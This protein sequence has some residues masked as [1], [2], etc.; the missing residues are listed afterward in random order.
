MTAVA[1]ADVQG[2]KQHASRW[3]RPGS[4]DIAGRA[5]PQIKVHAQEV[6]HHKAGRS[7]NGRVR[8]RADI[9]TSDC[10]A[11]ADLDRTDGDLVARQAL[12][13]QLHSKRPREFSLGGI[14]QNRS[15][16]HDRAT[17]MV[18]PVEG[19]VRQFN[20]TLLCVDLPASGLELH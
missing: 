2:C 9:A 19:G 10:M 6:V 11:P 16:G 14:E 5:G 8:P 17:S 18:A 4:P 1:P 20:E 12:A 13:A 3:K 7:L 15:R